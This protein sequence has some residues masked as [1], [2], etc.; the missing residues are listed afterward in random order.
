MSL[1]CQNQARQTDNGATSAPFVEAISDHKFL[2]FLNQQGDKLVINGFLHV[3]TGPSGA[4]LTGVV[5]DA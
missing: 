3:Q 2:G 4:V 5:K 1:K